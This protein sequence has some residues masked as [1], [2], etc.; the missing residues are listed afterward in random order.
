M[1]PPYP[2]PPGKRLAAP[3]LPGERAGGRGRPARAVFGAL[4]YGSGQ[5]LAQ[6]APQKSGDR[7]A[8]FLAQIAQTWPED[9][10]VL[11]MDNVSYHRSHGDARLV[12]GAGWTRMTPFWL[13][14]YTPNLNL[15]ERVWRFS[16][17]SW[18]VTASGMTRR[19]WRQLPRDCSAIWKPTSMQQ[20]DQP[21]SCA[22]T[23]VKLLQ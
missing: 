15:I 13:P 4:D 17:R 10:L 20:R 2:P 3:R 6:V 16:S 11:V 21:S 5:V 9:H 23:S 7:F 1:R 22:K 19:D 14:A 12:G 8:A 18:P